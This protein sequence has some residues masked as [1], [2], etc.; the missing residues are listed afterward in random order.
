MAIFCTEHQ[1]IHSCKYNS[2]K[3]K[4]VKQEQELKDKMKKWRK[5]KI[6]KIDKNHEIEKVIENAKKRNY[7]LLHNNPIDIKEINKIQQENELSATERIKVLKQK[8]G[9]K[10]TI[11]KP[12]EIQIMPITKDTTSIAKIIALSKQKQQEN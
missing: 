12:S 7:E 9:G 2:S 3:F 11:F 4:L 8:I 5:N 6:M 10:R 1:K